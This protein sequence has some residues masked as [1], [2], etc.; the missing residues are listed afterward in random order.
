MIYRPT[1]LLEWGVSHAMVPTPMRLD[2][3]TIR[4]YLG[5]CDRQGISRP[6]FVDVSIADPLRILR[7]SE[8][9][10]LDIG[11]PGTFDE[12]GVLPCSIV[13]VDENKKYLYY[14]G[15]ELGTRIRYRL[16]TGMAVSHDGG[17][18]FER[19]KETPVLERSDRELYFRGGPFCLL[20]NGIFRLWYV[21]G[22]S[23]VEI[24]GKP[25]PEYDIRYLE[26]PDG[27]RWGEEGKVVVPISGED[28]HGFGRPYVVPSPEGGFQMYYSV[29]R[30][31][32]KA[33]RL[34][35]AESRDGK[36]WSRVDDRLNLDVSASGFDDQAIMYAA[37]IDVNGTRYL[38]YNGNDFGR[39][40]FAAAVLEDG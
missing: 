29:R 16:L 6:G 24:D 2:A 18:T 14:V 35:F 36:Q 32:F 5:F 30:R 10:L 27:I 28:E 12:N 26:S 39:E 13:S 34:G 20:E 23:W 7:V 21:A 25:M 31:S 22:S 8:E 15:F 9:P 19:V 37:S 33:Y 40:G 17:E 1:G 4:I 38:F 3:E 11:R